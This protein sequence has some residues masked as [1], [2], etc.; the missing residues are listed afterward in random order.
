MLCA[1]LLNKQTWRELILSIIKTNNTVFKFAICRQDMTVSYPICK[2]VELLSS[3]KVQYHYLISHTT[4]Q[5]SMNM[6]Y[7]I[8]CHSEHEIIYFSLSWM[9]S[10][11]IWQSNFFSSTG[12]NVI[13][14]WQK[15]RPAAVLVW[16]Y[17]EENLHF[18]H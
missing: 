10:S 2:R 16:Q 18:I 15:A 17:Q 3:G 1:I 7:A 11:H 14:H 9:T 8:P 13:F 4:R 5:T 12:S 6:A